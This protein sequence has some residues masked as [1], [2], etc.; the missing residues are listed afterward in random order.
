MWRE[1]GVEKPR[2]EHSDCGVRIHQ[3]DNLAKNGR[4][5][6]Q[7]RIENQMIMVLGGIFE[8]QSDGLVVAGAITLVVGRNISD[9]FRLLAAELPDRRV[10]TVVDN[11]NSVNK[12]RLQ[13]IEATPEFDEVGMICYD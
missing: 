10:V 3:P 6:T 11:D 4:V 1:I 9:R 2:L 12:N 7:I 5:E 8:R 13:R